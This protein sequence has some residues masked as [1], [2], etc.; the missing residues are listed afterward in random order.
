M[1]HTKS[2]FFFKPKPKCTHSYNFRQFTQQPKIIHQ[3]VP[4]D[5]RALRRG[6]LMQ[7][8][9]NR[10]TL[11]EALE[12]ALT[13]FRLFSVTILY[14]RV[15]TF[16]LVE[17]FNYLPHGHLISHKFFAPSFEVPPRVFEGFRSSSYHRRTLSVVVVDY[18]RCDAFLAD[19]KLWSAG[20]VLFYSQS[21]FTACARISIVGAQKH[22]T[23][24]RVGESRQ[25]LAS[26]L[27]L[28]YGRSVGP[29]PRLVSTTVQCKYFH[30]LRQSH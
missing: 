27:F 6:S 20:F 21:S 7:L 30:H 18:V 16:G 25:L 22:F 3:C 17:K 28:P 24:L 12:I 13:I 9:E 11:Y 5:F 2:S 15:P 29:L 19:A 8:R 23:T 1:L 26:H 10:L 4:P 14:L